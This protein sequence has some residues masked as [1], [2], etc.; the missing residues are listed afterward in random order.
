MKKVFS[1]LTSFQNRI[2]RY[3][4]LV[5]LSVPLLYACDSGKQRSIERKS[6]RLNSSH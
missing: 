3:L 4:V 5:I 6:T 1:I 2:N